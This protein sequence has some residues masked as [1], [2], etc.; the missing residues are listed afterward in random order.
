MVC[1]SC[2][3]AISADSPSGAL[4]VRARHIKVAKRSRRVATNINTRL[5]NNVPRWRSGRRARKGAGRSAPRHKSQGRPNPGQPATESSACDRLSPGGGRRRGAVAQAQ[6]QGLKLNALL[7]FSGSKF[8]TWCFQA[9]IEL[10]PP[11]R[12][13]T[14]ETL[15]IL[16]SD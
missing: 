10:A 9:R 13:V 14:E 11:Q 2:T 8:G 16:L 6:K 1:C 3:Q 7:T 4:V 15:N 12:G 5:E